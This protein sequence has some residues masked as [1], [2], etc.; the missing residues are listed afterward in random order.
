VGNLSDP[1]FLGL[2]SL[3]CVLVGFIGKS[4]LKR[5]DSLEALLRQEL[6]EIYSVLHEHDKELLRI[7]TICATQHNHAG[8]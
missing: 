1:L 4:V 6:G 2:L 3:L 7:K 8:D 5:L